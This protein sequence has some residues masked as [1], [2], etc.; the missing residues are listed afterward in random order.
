M[1]L[2]GIPHKVSEAD[3]QHCGHSRQGWLGFDDE[4]DESDGEI[5]RGGCFGDDGD[6]DDNGYGDDDGD[7]CAGE[8]MVMMMVEGIAGIPGKVGPASSWRRL[9]SC[10]IDSETPNSFSAATAPLHKKWSVTIVKVIS[11]PNLF[12]R[13]VVTTL[14]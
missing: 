10:F 9:K 5:G 11:L 13:Y 12:S 6:G 3:G 1:G 8:M 4:D 7:G 2:S 14:L